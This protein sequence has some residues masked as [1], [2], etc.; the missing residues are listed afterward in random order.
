MWHYC[1]VETVAD[2][3][4]FDDFFGESVQCNIREQGLHLGPITCSTFLVVFIG[5]ERAVVSS[6]LLLRLDR[7]RESVHFTEYQQLHRD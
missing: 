2:G 6:M 1:V 5:S 4:G 3:H 7:S